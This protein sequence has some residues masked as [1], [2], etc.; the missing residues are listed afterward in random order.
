MARASL[1]HQMKLCIPHT[2]IAML[3]SESL[4]CPDKNKSLDIWD[5]IP[6]VLYLLV[7]VPRH[8]VADLVISKG[9]W[10]VCQLSREKGEYRRY[11]ACLFLSLSLDSRLRPARAPGQARRV[12]ATPAAAPPGFGLRGGSL[13]YKRLRAII[14]S[15]HE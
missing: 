2:R 9:Y 10:N 5:R 1:R 4:L 6:H 14:H 11:N 7:S 13:G 8:V 3:P 12:S 15:I